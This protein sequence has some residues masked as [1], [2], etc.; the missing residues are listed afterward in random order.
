MLAKQDG[1]GQA[2]VVQR[3]ERG[4]VRRCHLVLLLHVL[5]AELAEGPLG[6][7]CYCKALSATSGEM[8]NLPN[9]ISKL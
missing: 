8:G 6:T 2:R 5:F 9:S 7:F 3:T 4:R 1:R